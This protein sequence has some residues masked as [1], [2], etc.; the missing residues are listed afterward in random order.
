M[1]IYIEK[2]GTGKILH[3]LEYKITKVVSNTCYI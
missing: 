3:Y 1:T 2:I